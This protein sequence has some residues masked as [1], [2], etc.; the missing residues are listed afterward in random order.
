[1]PKCECAENTQLLFFIHISFDPNLEPS[2][3][4]HTKSTQNWKKRDCKTAKRMRENLCKRCSC[5]T[6]PLKQEKK[7][8]PRL[9]FIAAYSHI[10][11]MWE[12]HD[13]RPQVKPRK[14]EKS[15]PLKKEKKKSFVGCSPLI[16]FHIK[17][18]PST[19]FPHGLK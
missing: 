8:N 13:N 17:F 6:V 4:A 1:M 14:L 5:K 7:F 18:C 10:E 15:K 2:E 11:M 19:L 12:T 9:L 16:P 3:M